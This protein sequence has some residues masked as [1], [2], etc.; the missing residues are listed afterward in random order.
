MSINNEKNKFNHN[1][2]YPKAKPRNEPFGLNKSTATFFGKGAVGAGILGTGLKALN[3]LNDKPN[4]NH[5]FGHVGS[6][7]GFHENEGFSGGTSISVGNGPA[8]YVGRK[9][10]P[11]LKDK[12][13]LDS[14]WARGMMKRDING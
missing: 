11:I 7:F 6:I 12:S 10:F 1:P 9:T 2:S 13:P 8:P 4:N 5:D 14:K 3:N